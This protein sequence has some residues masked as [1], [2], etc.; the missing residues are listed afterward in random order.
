MPRAAKGKSF[1]NR[2]FRD[3]ELQIRRASLAP[4]PV[5]DRTAHLYDCEQ[6]T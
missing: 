3:V 5:L 4:A 6:H 2:V 1:N